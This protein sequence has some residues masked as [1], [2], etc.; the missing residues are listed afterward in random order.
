VSAGGLF[1][2]AEKFCRSLFLPVSI[3]PV[4]NERVLIQG[5]LKFTLLAVVT[6]ANGRS[7][8]R[9]SSFCLQ[10]QCGPLLPWIVHDCET[11]AEKIVA[12]RKSPLKAG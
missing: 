8:M 2:F 12:P 10:T 6:L 3:L 4:S 9:H 5:Y 11:C 7:V 1:T